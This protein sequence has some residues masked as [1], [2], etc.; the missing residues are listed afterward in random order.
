MR[1][2]SGRGDI[3]ICYFC[4]ELT[5]LPMLPD[6]NADT[7][8]NA[9]PVSQPTRNWNPPPVT[10]PTTPPISNPPPTSRPT[11]SSFRTPSDSSQ[12]KEKQR[13]SALS[14]GTIL[15]IAVGVVL[16]MAFMV[17]VVHYYCSRESPT[18][19]PSEAVD[20]VLHE[21]DPRK[22][23]AQE[24]AGGD[25]DKPMEPGQAQ[26]DFLKPDHSIN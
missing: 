19:R 4:E 24:E 11:T 20:K 13:P 26:E 17:V 3:T 2:I 14:Q 10:R 16:A 7:V 18:P 1:T 25:G 5:N 6:T 22:M 9:R 23:R 8:S 15:G 21:K 12:Q